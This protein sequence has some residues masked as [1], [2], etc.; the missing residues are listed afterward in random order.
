MIT[1]TVKDILAENL[2]DCS[3][4][5]IYRFSDG[6]TTFYIGKS[7]EIEDRLCAHLG[8]GNKMGHL[9]MLPLIEENKPQSLD[10]TVTLYAIEDT[11]E[12]LTKEYE[13]QGW[14]IN[15]LML[16]DPSF[17]V[18]R[19]EVAM[20]RQFKP[21][22]NVIDSK[23]RTPLPEKYRQQPKDSSAFYIMDI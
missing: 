23:E 15:G 18:S 21:C 2:P 14:N 7:F 8:I 12:Y 1:L 5:F 17:V 6:D 19:A 9:P 16:T 22:L 4:H 10:W 20:I 11:R 3:L 13:P